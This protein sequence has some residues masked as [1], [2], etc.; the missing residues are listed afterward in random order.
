MYIPKTVLITGATGGF[1]VEFAKAF[2]GA[3]TSKIYLHGRSLEKLQ[4]LAKEL[5]C[6]VELIHCDLLDED[7]IEDA[8]S[9]I[10]AVDLLINNAGGAIG[11]EKADDSDWDDWTKMLQ[12]NVGSLMQITNIMLP[13]MVEAGRGHIINIG[14]VAGN[15]PYPGGHIYCASKAF[16]KQFSLAMRPD[17]LGKNVRVTNIEPGAVE[18]E[19]SLKRFKGDKEKADQVYRNWRALQAKDIADTVLFVGTLPEHVNITSLEVMSTDQANGPFIYH[20]EGNS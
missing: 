18:T 19:F 16:V 17:L 9:D 3:G 13:K 10:E 14:S 8:F 11:L 7:A 6:D 2:E 15:W 12:I 1:G 5:A 4:L 20:K